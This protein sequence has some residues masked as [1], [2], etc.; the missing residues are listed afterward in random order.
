[1]SKWS[2]AYRDSR[3]QK[4]RLQIMERDG[5]KCRACGRGEKDGTTLNV[6]HAYYESNKSPW[7]YPA[8][9]LITYCEDCHEERH[10]IQKRILSAMVNMSTLGISGL[11]LIAERF[12][13]VAENFGNYDETF[14]PDEEY[15]TDLDAYISEIA[16]N[17]LQNGVQEEGG[18]R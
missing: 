14:E 18:V 3:W 6:H 4:L 9:T 17:A 11:A 2:S 1:M 13:C 7:D 15:P 10:A 8:E 5:W 16:Q 12:L